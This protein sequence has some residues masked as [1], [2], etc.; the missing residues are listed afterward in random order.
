MTSTNIFAGSP[1]HIQKTA[2]SRGLSPVRSLS[3]TPPQMQSPRTSPVV[4]PKSPLSP[5]YDSAPRFEPFRP[6]SP[7]NMTTRTS[8]SQRRGSSNAL[9]LP[10]LPRFHP[11]NFPSSHSSLQPTPDSSQASPQRPASPRQHQRIISDAQKHLLAYQ[12]EMISAAVRSSTPVQL[13]NPESP[14]LAP[15]GSPGP[16]TPLQL[17]AE[18][19]GYLVAGAQSA[20]NEAVSTDELVAKLMKEETARQRTSGSRQSNR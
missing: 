2:P 8:V 12:R 17:E 15:L 18:D 7:R 5:R 6:P 13:D 1:K 20:T 4:R 19:G 11:S 16:V 3:T 10:S 14:R 9:K